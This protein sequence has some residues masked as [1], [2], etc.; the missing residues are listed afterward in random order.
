V[1]VSEANDPSGKR[2][3]P[4]QAENRLHAQKG[5]LAWLAEQD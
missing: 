3:L 5:L 1:V 4:D 2:W